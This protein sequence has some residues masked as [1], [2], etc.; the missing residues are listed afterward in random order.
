MNYKSKLLI[1]RH[2][3]KLLKKTY[4]GFHRFNLLQPGTG[5]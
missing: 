5:H 2:P 3:V 4:M 1:F